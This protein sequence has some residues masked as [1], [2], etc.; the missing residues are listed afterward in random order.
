MVGSNTGVLSRYTVVVDS[1][2]AFIVDGY[3]LLYHTLIA[4]MCS[5]MVG[6]SK[7]TVVVPSSILSTAKFP[8]CAT[9]KLR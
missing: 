2:G 5:P 9:G 1:A 7:P 6:C 3:I 8:F 4:G